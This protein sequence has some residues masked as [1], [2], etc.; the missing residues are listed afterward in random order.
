M[1]KKKAMATETQE[2]KEVVP[3]ATVGKMDVLRD[4]WSKATVAVTG[5]KAAIFRQV[6]P[7]ITKLFASHKLELKESDYN[8]WLSA[9]RQAGKIA[10]AATR[11]G[12]ATTPSQPY[13]AVEQALDELAQLKE[14]GWPVSEL[15]AVLTLIRAY[16]AK[17]EGLQAGINQVIHLLGRV[18][19][20]RQAFEARQAKFK[21][22]FS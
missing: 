6:Q 3:F 14:A 5:S 4:W 2:A 7:E 12:A 20:E 18:D 11:D 10:A 19:A 21:T 8:M 17:E 13:V 9:G 15:Q 16:E 1:A 22:L